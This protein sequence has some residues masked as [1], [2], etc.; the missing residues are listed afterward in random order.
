MV[1]GWWA[2]RDLQ[3]G[4]LT[5]L[6]ELAKGTAWGMPDPDRIERLDRRGFLAK[7]ADDRVAVT[8]KGHTALWVRR[9]SI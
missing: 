6:S 4:D 3:R 9:F 8:V 2:R 5:M 7:T 1:L